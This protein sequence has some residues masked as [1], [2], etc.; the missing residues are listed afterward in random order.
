MSIMI[1]YSFIINNSAISFIYRLTKFDFLKF[2]VSQAHHM[3]SMTM[4]KH[5]FFF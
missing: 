5:S 2:S 1:Y 3:T 4:L